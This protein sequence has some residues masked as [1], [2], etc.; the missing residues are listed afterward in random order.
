MSIL[1]DIQKNILANDPQGTT[2]DSKCFIRCC[3]DTLSETLPLPFK[4]CIGLLESGKLPVNDTKTGQGRVVDVSEVLRAGGSRL[5]IVDSEKGSVVASV[6]ASQITNEV[7]IRG[8]RSEVKSPI[9]SEKLAEYNE[10]V[11]KTQ[12][13]S[14][15]LSQEQQLLGKKILP[16]IDDLKAK[17]G[18][19]P[20]F[21]ISISTPRGVLEET[22]FMS[23]E[24]AMV[25][26]ASDI[27]GDKL[28]RPSESDISVAKVLCEPGLTVKLI[29]Q[30]LNIDE[31]K[32]YLDPKS[33]KVMMQSPDIGEIEFAELTSS[34]AAL[35]E[36]RAEELASLQAN[37]GNGLSYEIISK[38]F[39]N[40]PPT[41]DGKYYV[42]SSDKT[43]C[44]KS[45]QGCVTD[46]LSGATIHVPFSDSSDSP[47]DI[48]VVKCLSDKHI[49][50]IGDSRGRAV[51]SVSYSDSK[52]SVVFS[53]GL[54]TIK[55]PELTEKIKEYRENSDRGPETPV[56]K[57]DE[58][59]SVDDRNPVDKGD[60]G[61]DDLEI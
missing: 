15:G 28:S 5:L 1:E 44:A 49:V 9:L 35:V 23:F 40:H 36:R 31:I 47:C 20:H 37:K 59:P 11:F 45:L 7:T 41:E 32:I 8:V 38:I 12:E 18:N 56:L 39:D 14:P 17:I 29:S 4:D 61:D 42:T 22:P 43:S 24:E 2:L 55:I 16:T 21:K 46:I 52:N 30:S 6:S 10:R 34:V 13:C 57:G 51:A 19:P 27:P 25:Y 48:D 54:E 50:S 58:S 60:K 53:T 26:V 3:T 33:G